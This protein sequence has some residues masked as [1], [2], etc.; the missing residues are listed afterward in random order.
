VVYIAAPANTYTGG[1][2]ALFQV[3]N[4]L[5]KRGINAII[6]FYGEYHDNPIHPNYLKYQCPWIRMNSINDDYKHAIIIPE[7]AIDRAI[8][9]TK[10]VKIIYWLAVDNFILSMFPPKILNF[11]VYIIRE[12]IFDPYILYSV[13]TGYKKTYYNSYLGH[14]VNSLIK[15]KEVIIPRAD[16]HLVQ[17]KYAKDFL[18]RHGIKDDIILQ[19]HE[20]IEEEFLSKAKNI[21]HGEKVDAIAWNAR[22]AYP[23]A[24]KLVHILRRHGFLVYD[25]ANVGKQNMIKILS[26]TKLFLDIGIHQVGIGLSVKLLP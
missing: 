1:P 24:F 17:S 8:R 23:I 12:Y 2:T 14:Y 16:L 21:N 13:I 7:T 18:N 25:L 10:V 5:R 20:P 3:C 15:R 4:A 9:F 6:A 11:M 26:K 19:V 22:K